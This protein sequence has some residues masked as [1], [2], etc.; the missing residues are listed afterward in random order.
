MPGE[1]RE[2]DSFDGDKIIISAK[3]QEGV[4]NSVSMGSEIPLIRV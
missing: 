1:K 2:D 4:K 3:N